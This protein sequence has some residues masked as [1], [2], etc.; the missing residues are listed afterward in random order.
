MNKPPGQV[1]ESLAKRLVGPEADDRQSE[2]VHGKLIVLHILAKD[3]GDAELS[4]AP[5]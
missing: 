5:A 2:E 1:D 3:I 4:I